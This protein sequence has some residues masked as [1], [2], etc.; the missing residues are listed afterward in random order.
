[1]QA[2]I[3]LHCTIL[4]CGSSPHSSSDTLYKAEFLK[5][6]LILL[7]FWPHILGHILTRMD[8]LC[9]TFGFQLPMLGSL[10]CVSPFQP[11]WAWPP[12]T[13]PPPMW[14]LLYLA[15]LLTP[16]WVISICR[17]C[18]HLAHAPNPH[19][20]SS[21]LHYTLLSSQASTAIIRKSLAL[22]GL[23]S[24]LW[25]TMTLSSWPRMF[26]LLAGFPSSSYRTE[27]LGNGRK[28]EGWREKEVEQLQPFRWLWSFDPPGGSWALAPTLPWL[29]VSSFFFYRWREKYKLKHVFLK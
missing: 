10:P 15:Q 14:C 8:T 7:G 12:H 4:L 23:N 1:M 13:I 21:P 6:H 5:K 25:V 24:P 29:S 9:T 22:R 18:L 2:L 16:T 20:G 27:M 28:A 3:L 19:A 26:I 17:Q 11:I